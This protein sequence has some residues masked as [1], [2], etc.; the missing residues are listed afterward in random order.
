MERKIPLTLMVLAVLG[1][2]Y[3]LMPIVV[4]VLAGLLK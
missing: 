1:F 4:V 3:M 2:A